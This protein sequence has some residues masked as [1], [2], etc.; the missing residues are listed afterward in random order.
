MVR[1]AQGW[2]GE[3]GRS[4]WKA[5]L[6][7]FRK[8]WQKGLPKLRIVQAYKYFSSPRVTYRP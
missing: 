4:W 6:P 2:T 3:T 7:N 1:M 8:K 5:D